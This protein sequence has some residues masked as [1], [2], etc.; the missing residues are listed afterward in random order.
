MQKIYL[1]MLFISGITL[2][3]QQSELQKKDNEIELIN[4]K[5][6]KLVELTNKLIINNNFK[7]REKK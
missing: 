4:K 1:I 5:V 2:V 6:K 3:Y 7:E